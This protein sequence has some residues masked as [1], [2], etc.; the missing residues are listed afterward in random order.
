MGELKG[1]VR[2]M[3][4]E[5]GISHEHPE[6]YQRWVDYW[7]AAA[8]LEKQNTGHCP[9]CD[10]RRDKWILQPED[11]ADEVKVRIDP[12]ESEI[13]NRLDPL[14]SCLGCYFAIE[15]EI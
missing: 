13:Y 9:V 14:L 5:R 7:A 3:E 10:D 6:S 12:F 4:K 8:E 15:S 11:G 1:L 2:A